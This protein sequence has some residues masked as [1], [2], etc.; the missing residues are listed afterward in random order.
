MVQNVVQIHVPFS[1][2]EHLP[3]GLATGNQ[4]T[5]TRSY[6][7][8]TVH[9]L[10]GFPQLLLMS[11]CCSRIPPRTPR[12][13]ESSRVL[14]LLWAGMVLQTFPVLIT[15]TVLRSI[16]HVLIECPSI[17]ICLLFFS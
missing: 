15:L 13:I 6:E 8:Y 12:Y 3:W 5:L 11:S 1:D 16:R 9:A 14:G 4:P 17:R 10:S 2:Y 7:L